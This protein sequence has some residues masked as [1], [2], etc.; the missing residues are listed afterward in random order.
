MF[1]SVLTT[2]SSSA[3]CF[4]PL[5]IF[6]ISNKYNEGLNTKQ[7]SYYKAKS[8]CLYGVVSLAEYLVKGEK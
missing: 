1:S 3:A 6:H 2:V 8:C 5:A 4:R 7:T